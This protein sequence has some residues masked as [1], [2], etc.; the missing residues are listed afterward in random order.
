MQVDGRPPAGLSRTQSRSR[1]THI[2]SR[3][4]VK[5]DFQPP[6]DMQ[7]SRKTSSALGFYQLPWGSS[8]HYYLN[9]ALKAWLLPVTLLQ[10][11]WVISIILT[12]TMEPQSVPSCHL[13]PLLRLP[14]PSTHRC[15]LLLSVTLT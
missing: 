5:L 14:A 13:P 4:F 15:L 2:Y 9:L 11:L 3:V 12:M 7:S 1:A 8:G 6:P 10:G